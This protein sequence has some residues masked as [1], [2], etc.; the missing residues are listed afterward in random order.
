MLHRFDKSQMIEML[1]M[2]AEQ[3]EKVTPDMTVK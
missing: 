3:I 2:G 1:P